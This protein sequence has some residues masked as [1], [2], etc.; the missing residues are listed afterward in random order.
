MRITQVQS[1]N[2]NY[3]TPLRAQKP[4]TSTNFTGLGSSISK[5]Y[6]DF[7]EGIA[8]KYYVGFYKSGFAS[9]FAKTTKGKKW[10]NDMPTHM[11]VLGSTL[12]SGMYIVRTLSNDKLDEKR[13]KTLAINDA[14]TWVVSTACTYWLNR[15]LE[16]WWEDV[17]TRFVADYVLDHPEIKR[18]KLLG[19]WD[20]AEIKIVMG[21]WHEVVNARIDK[22]N[23]KIKSP[24]YNNE[25]K[26]LAHVDPIKNIKDFNVEVLKNPKLSTYIDGMGIRKSLFIFGMIYRYIVPVL[27]M[28]P[29]NKIGK[30][31][32]DKNEAKNQQQNQAVEKK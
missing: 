2:Q 25:R 29:A 18:E 15:K 28:K 6:D 1:Y 14:L 16:G 26:E 23:K 7:V 13:R 10:A 31:L 5:G 32:H 17:T 22:I 3:G 19:N 8:N 21:K 4:Q 12:I 9:W 11:A 20:P 24:G 27:V 30:M